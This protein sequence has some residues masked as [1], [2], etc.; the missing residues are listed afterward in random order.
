MMDD[1]GKVMCGDAGGEGKA[2]YKV[3]CNNQTLWWEMDNKENKRRKKKG[4]EKN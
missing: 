3:N 4:K 1:C 2:S